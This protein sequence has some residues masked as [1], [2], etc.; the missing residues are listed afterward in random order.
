MRISFI[1]KNSK[2]ARHGDSNQKLPELGR[3]WDENYSKPEVS[4]GYIVS[5]KPAKAGE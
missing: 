5:S 3:L 4:V 1:S 2:R